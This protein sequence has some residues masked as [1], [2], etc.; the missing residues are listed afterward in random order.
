MSFVANRTV[1]FPRTEA[2]RPLLQKPPKGVALSLRAIW[3]AECTSMFIHV[4]GIELA[5]EF[6]VSKGKYIETGWQKVRQA[7][8]TRLG[9]TAPWFVVGGDAFATFC[10]D[11][12]VNEAAYLEDVFRTKASEKWKYLQ[13]KFKEKK[14]RTVTFIDDDGKVVKKKANCTDEQQ[15]D[16]IDWPFF[17]LMQQA[18]LR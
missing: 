17:D 18:M 11:Y 16:P 8:A 15:L 6:D 10:N 13:D 7:M 9:A 12:G 3:D 14:R 2:Q 1:E 4:R 5:S